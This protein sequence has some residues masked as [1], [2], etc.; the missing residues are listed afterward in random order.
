MAASNFPQSPAVSFP[1][2]VDLTIFSSNQIA[3]IV[4]GSATDVVVTEGG[5]IPS[6]RKAL[7]DNFYFKSPTPW[8]I[9]ESETTF[10]QLR[11]FSDSTINGWFYSPTATTLNPVPMG[12]TPIGDPKWVLYTLNTVIDDSFLTNRGNFVTG[13]VVARRGDIFTYSNNGSVNWCQYKGSIP[14]TITTN[15]PSTDGGIFSSTNPSGL[16]EVVGDY[17]LLG[18]GIGLSSQQIVA[19]FDWQNFVFATGASYLVSTLSWLNVPAGISYPSGIAI[20]IDVNSITNFGEVSLTLRPNTTVLSDFIIYEVLITGAIGSRTYSVKTA[21]TSAKPVPVSGGGTG[22]NTLL[23]AKTVLGITALENGWTW[24]GNAQVGWRKDPQGN[25][26]QWNNTVSV[27]TAGVVTIS[28]PITF[29]NTFDFVEAQINSSTIYTAAEA[30]NRYSI[31]NNSS[32]SFRNGSS[33]L[34]GVVMARAWGK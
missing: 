6:I 28:F 1:Q 3:G 30:N 5:D 16:W 4:N 9:G 14:H 22:E 24:G 34:S 18:L 29:P 31:I 8:V 12:A 20:S 15:N 19:S 33:T 2:A 7:A 27:T 10:N 32:F 23:G 25:I 21:W 11:L 13:G 17:R 26:E